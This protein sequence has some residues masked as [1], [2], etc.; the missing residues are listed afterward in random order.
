MTNYY[1]GERHTKTNALAKVLSHFGLSCGH[2]VDAAQAILHEVTNHD[3]GDLEPINLRDSL[4][5]MEDWHEVD[6]RIFLLESLN[7]IATSLLNITD[8]MV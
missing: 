1:D 7:M 3:T 2:S 6:D 8:A 5:D 4:L